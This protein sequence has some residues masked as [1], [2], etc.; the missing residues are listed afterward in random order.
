MVFLLFG[1]RLELVL[2]WVCFV[3]LCFCVCGFCGFTSL[4]LFDGFGFTILDLLF[5]RLSFSV[6]MFWILVL[7]FPWYCGDWMH[8]DL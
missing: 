5:C 1:F 4:C 3:V 2:I 6:R 7:G 8:I